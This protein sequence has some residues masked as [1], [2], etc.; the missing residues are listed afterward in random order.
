M[1]DKLINQIS[2]LFSLL[3]MDNNLSVDFFFFT[4]PLILPHPTCYHPPYGFPSVNTLF[5]IVTTLANLKFYSFTI[6]FT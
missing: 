5:S 2:T 6:L 1:D 4:D 3:N